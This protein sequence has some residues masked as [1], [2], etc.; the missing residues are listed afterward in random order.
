VVGISADPWDRQRSFDAKNQLN[1]LLLS[2]PDRS[3]AKQFG[4]KRLGSL[5]NKRQTFVVGPNRQTLAVI[6]SETDMVKHAD[7]ALQALRDI[8]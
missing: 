1:Y 8:Q 4:V 3:I 6:A 5:P 7:G 2:D